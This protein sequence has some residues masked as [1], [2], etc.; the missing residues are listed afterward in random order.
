MH[1]QATLLFPG[2]LLEESAPAMILSATPEQITLETKADL[3]RGSDVRVRVEG[4]TILGYVAEIARGCVTIDIDRVLPMIPE[5]SSLFFHVNADAALS[6]ANARS[7][8]MRL[9]ELR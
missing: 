2:L 8:V 9:A 1:A 5:V 3:E 7:E 6:R 4:G